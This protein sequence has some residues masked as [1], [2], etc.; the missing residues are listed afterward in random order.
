MIYTL[1]TIASF[2]IITYYF[3]TDNKEKD[4]ASEKSKNLPIEQVETT[5]K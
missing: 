1:I 3:V 4:N 2:G 5:E